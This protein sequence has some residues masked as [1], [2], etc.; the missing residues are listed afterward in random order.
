MVTIIVLDT[1]FKSSTLFLGNLFYLK[2][3]QSIKFI[4]THTY[5]AIERFELSTL[6]HEPNEFPFTPFSQKNNSCISYILIIIIKHF[7]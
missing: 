5:W 1:M 3:F 2:F 6:G 4:Y 7:K